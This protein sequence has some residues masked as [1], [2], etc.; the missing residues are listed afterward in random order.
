MLTG[1]QDGRLVHNIFQIRAGEVRRSQRDDS[2]INVIGQRL[3]LGMNLQDLLAALYVGVID[4]D[5]PVKPAGTQQRRIQNIRTVGGRHDNDALVGREAVHFNQQLVERLLALIVTAAQAGAAMTADRVDLID[6]NN[7]RRVLLRLI[8][9]VADTARADADE[10][11]YKVGTGD[12]EERHACLAGYRTGQ[13]RLAGAGRANQQNALGNARAHVQETLGILQELDDFTQL[14]GL[15]LRARHIV[16]GHFVLFRIVHPRA[17]TAEVHYALVG[18]AALLTHDKVNHH[19]EQNEA[20]QQR[21]HFKPPGRSFRHLHRDGE[22]VIADADLI[23]VHVLADCIDFIDI[24]IELLN[25]GQQ[26]R[27][28]V[29]NAELRSRDAAVA[30]GSDQRIAAGHHSLQLVRLN[31][32]QNFRIIQLLNFIAFSGTE[33]PNN[34]QNQH[35]QQNIHQRAL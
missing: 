3:A 28:I 14:L 13:Q 6:E 24:R 16:E 19:A 17:G 29:T 5:L 21:Q 4:H 34:G 20:D 33:H 1:S 18:A 27:D 23:D 35:D 30:R 26:R 9:Q 7:G 25:A 31:H 10:H 2:Q 32:F 12:G 15:L 11:L 22:P 8:K